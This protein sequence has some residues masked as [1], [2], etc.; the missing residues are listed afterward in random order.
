MGRKRIEYTEDELNSLLRS[1][2]FE[3]IEARKLTEFAP[4]D[5][6]RNILVDTI[7]ESQEEV[8]GS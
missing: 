6:K 5:S 4:K 3:I 2:L 1:E 8:G 7:L